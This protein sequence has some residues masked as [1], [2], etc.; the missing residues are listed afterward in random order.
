MKA[1]KIKMYVF[2][3]GGVVLRNYDV[4]PQITEELQISK[5]GFISLPVRIYSFFPTVNLMSLSFGGGFRRLMAAKSGK[6][7]S[8]SISPRNW[9]GRWLR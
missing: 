9:T 7:F 2:D 4:E 3:M 5:K 6:T 1:N 8:A